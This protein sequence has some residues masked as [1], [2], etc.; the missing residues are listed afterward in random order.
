MFEALRAII[1]ADGDDFRRTLRRIA[2]RTDDA[3]DSFNDGA[4]AAEALGDET[5]AASD[6]VSDAD[7]NISQTSETVRNFGSDAEAAAESATNFGDA[8]ESATEG[9]FDFDSDDFEPEFESDDTRIPS[10]EERAARRAAEGRDSFDEDPFGFLEDARSASEAVDDAAE[11]VDSADEAV[12]D[13]GDTSDTAGDA[14]SGMIDDDVVSDADTFSESVDKADE[15]LR[16]MRAAA[17]GFEE[18]NVNPFGIDVDE[19]IDSEMRG[20]LASGPEETTGRGTIQPQLIADGMDSERVRKFRAA[21]AGTSDQIVEFGDDTD[22][23]VDKL[24]DLDGGLTGLRRTMLS[25]SSATGILSGVIGAVAGSSS[26]ATAKSSILAAAQTTQTG[27]ALSAAVANGTLKASL[28]GLAV[29]L[30]VVISLVSALIAVLAGLALVFA[31]AGGGL[32]ALFGAGLLP[33]AKDFKQASED[34]ESIWGG[35]AAIF[36][37]AAKAARSAVAPL[38]GIDG[39]GDLAIATLNKAID[40]LSKI[41]QT[42]ADLAPTLRDLFGA[43]F[44]IDVLTPIL[45]DLKRGI[46]ELQPL[47]DDIIRGSLRALAGAVDVVTDAAIQVGPE[48]AGI[49]EAL[50][51][52]GPEL[53]EIGALLIDVFGPSVE[54]LIRVL[55]L[56]LAAI[57]AILKIIKPFVDV[58]NILINGFVELLKLLQRF[59]GNAAKE[60]EQFL[61]SIDILDDTLTVIDNAAG[62]DNSRTGGAPDDDSDRLPSPSRP[63]GPA[64]GQDRSDNNQEVNVTVN[65]NNSSPQETARLVEKAVQRALRR[66]RQQQQGTD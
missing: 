61:G 14:L 5:D 47:L 65:S 6:V 30:T 45:N 17:E 19:S 26:V 11:S 23:A 46:R 52:L 53:V 36:K 59:F 37:R 32:I 31:A 50:A 39:F 44:Q 18:G 48:L 63:A 29:A 24:G 51:G 13:F 33:I 34:I 21:I 49:T 10:I 55:D 54:G 58:I 16:E 62:A 4:D 22:D 43:L 12:G 1:T 41:A 40:G 57:A 20:S 38:K 25:S 56:T 35:F 27:T 15:R 28:A 60:T 7:D 2:N 8:V 3:A 64:R 66:Q 9:D 42:V